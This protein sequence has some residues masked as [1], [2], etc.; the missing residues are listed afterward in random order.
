MGF[1]T[2][3]FRAFSW[4]LFEVFLVMSGSYKEVKLLGIG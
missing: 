4:V 3:L 1:L 2:L